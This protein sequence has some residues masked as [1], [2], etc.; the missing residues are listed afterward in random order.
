MVLHILH[1]LP[2]RVLS[3]AA[4]VCKRWHRLTQDESLWSRMDLSYHQLQQGALGHII[5]RQV[6]I[7]RLT[8]AKI[9]HPPILPDSCA[10]SEDFRSRLLL[11][12]LSMVNISCDSLVELFKRCNRLKKLSLEH[13]KVNENVLSALSLSKNLEILNLAMVEG[14]NEKG[15]RYLLSN[16]QNIRELNLAWTYLNVN[17]IQYICT[18]LPKTLDR[19]NISGCRK[20]L[21][22]K[23]VFELVSRCKD[24]RE[25]DLS[26]CTSVTGEAVSYITMLRDLNFLAVSRCYQIS[27]KSLLQLKKIPSLLYLDVHGGYVDTTELRHVQENLGSHVQINKFKFSSVA[28][29]TVGTRRSSIWNMRVRD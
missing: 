7:L 22:D 11:L 29:P 5:S 4:L 28:R 26:D 21:S 23:N 17:S 19:L 9:V 18:N 6:M 15:L 16:C 14:I 10:Y 1:F 13:V 20:L 12:D 8:Q 27:Y 25:L 2:K 24:L 3:T